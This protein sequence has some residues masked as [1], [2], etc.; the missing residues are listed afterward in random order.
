M[1]GNTLMVATFN[2]NSIRSRLEQILEWLPRV[3][4]DVLC[5]Q[6]TR[7]QDQDFPAQ[8]FI[9]AGYHVAYR[10]QKSHAGVAVISREEPTDV[11]YGFDDG[12]SA[13]EARLI[14]LR[15]GGIHIVNT[16]VPEGRSID[17]EMFAYKLAWFA[18]LKALFERHYTPQ[19]DLLWAGDLN[20][21]PEAIDVYDP[22]GLANTVDFHPHV[23][24]AF[25]EV[26]AWG[27]VDVY[28]QHHPGEPDQ[29]SYF[30]YRLRNALQ[31]RLG[32]RIDHLMATPGLARRATRSWIDLEAR[33]AERPSDHTFVVA[34]FAR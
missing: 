18:R 33:A 13:D 15:V 12:G 32:W 2:A 16:Y 14:R 4:A 21:A 30:D 10:G 25:A 8:P 1:T 31:R 29:Y 28:R 20:V 5:V 34:E 6:E 11:V 17:H 24:E 27:L 23:R 19:D 7:V 22:E 3:G 9:D 26:C